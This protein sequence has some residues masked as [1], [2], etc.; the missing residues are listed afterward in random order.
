MTTFID[1]LAADG[2]K[3]ALEFAG[4]D[5]SIRSLTR[6]F[7]DD[8]Q[9]Y[10]TTGTQDVKG[11]ARRV[12][13]DPDKPSTETVRSTDERWLWRAKTDQTFVPNDAGA[14]DTLHVGDD[15]GVTPGSSIVAA[16]PITGVDDVV[17]WDLH[18]RRGG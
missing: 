7:D 8:T 18:V 9:G 16:R 14:L 11:R 13:F 1:T 10:T 17:L 5:M 15:P 2:A 4:V 6:T 3:L 12:E